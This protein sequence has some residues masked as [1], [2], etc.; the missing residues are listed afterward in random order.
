MTENELIFEMNGMD[1]ADW[2]NNH[3]LFLMYLYGYMGECD[4]ES[5]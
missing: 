3:R 4:G 5:C 1:F 2:I